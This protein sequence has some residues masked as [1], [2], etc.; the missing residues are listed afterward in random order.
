MIPKNH[1]SFFKSVSEEVGVHKDVVDDL[2][3]FYYAKVRKTLSN[4]EHTS[5]SVSNLGTFSLRKTK[6]EKA[7]KKNKDIAG[8]LQKMK[9]KDYDKYVPVKAKLEKM[10]KMLEKLNALINKKKKFKNEN[11]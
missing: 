5:I 1:K 7:I 9:Y 4:L 8:N 3:T 6:L 2:V 11:K 10:E